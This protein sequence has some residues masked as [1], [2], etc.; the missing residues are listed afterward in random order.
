MSFKAV[1]VHGIH[2]YIDH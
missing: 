1:M 2:P